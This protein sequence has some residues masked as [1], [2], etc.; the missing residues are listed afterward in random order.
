MYYEIGVGVHPDLPRALEWYSKSA[1]KGFGPALERMKD[2]SNNKRMN[3]TTTIDNMG[4]Q[5]TKYT[6]R[7]GHQKKKYYE[8]SIRIAEKS[9]KAHHTEQNCQVM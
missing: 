5:L 3:T 9:R 7:G 8:E 1:S 2:S 4:N 6:S